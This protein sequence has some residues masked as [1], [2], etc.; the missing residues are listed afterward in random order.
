M[1]VTPLDQLAALQSQDLKFRESNWL[2]AHGHLHEIQYEA[3]A[4]LV[5]T[6]LAR[7][8]VSLFQQKYFQQH[9]PCG[10]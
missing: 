9:K 3:T 6:F 1:A 5:S 10:T 4:D 2:R 8:I 7:A